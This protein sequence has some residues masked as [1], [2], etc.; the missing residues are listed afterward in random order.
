MSHLFAFSLCSWGSQGKNSE[1]ICHSLPQQTMFCQALAIRDVPSAAARSWTTCAGSPRCTTLSP[2]RMKPCCPPGLLA[3]SGAG[4]SGARVGCSDLTQSALNSG[5]ASA[6]FSF[7]RCPE[8]AMP[9]T[10]HWVLTTPESRLSRFWMPEARIQVLAGSAPFAGSGGGVFPGGLPP[11]VLG[12]GPSGLVGLLAAPGISVL[13]L[14]PSCLGFCCHTAPY[15]PMSPWR[16]QSHQGKG[17]PRPRMTA[18]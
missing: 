15:L 1:G 9:G 5:P 8:A 16:H 7:A 10:I 11:Q 6:T 4:A 18:L 14:R 3:A 12:E 13:W 17:P 2:P